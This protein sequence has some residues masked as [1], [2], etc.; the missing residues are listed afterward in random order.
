[1]SQFISLEVID[2]DGTVRE[3]AESAG[4]TRRDLMRNAGIAGAGALAGGVLFNGLISPAEAA[5]SSR[6]RSKAN[7]IKILQ[8]ALTLEYL[9]AEFYKQANASGA[10]TDLNLKRFAE[11]TGKHEAEHVAALKKVLGKKAPKVPTF[12]FKDTV[13]DQAKFAA[14]AEAVEDVGV[15]AYAGQGP[16]ILQRAVVIPALAIHSVEARHAAWIRF[17][18]SGGQGDEKV[19]P[20]PASFD[21][22]RTEKAV[23]KIVGGTGFIVS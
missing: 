16:N 10:I 19:L 18:N 9:E 13:T 4:A 17:I 11:V 23:L 7:D 1:M 20:A 3:A 14:T 15:S 8:Y 2:A 6:K 5:I 12:D 22:A 21:A